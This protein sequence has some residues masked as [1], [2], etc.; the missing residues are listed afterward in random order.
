MLNPVVRLMRLTDGK[1]GATLG[2]VYHM[3]SEL[4]VAFEKPIEGMDEAVREKM[5]ALFMAR[6]TYFHKP[7]FT[8]A[9]FLDAE[10]LVGDGSEAEER[11][12]REV[13]KAVASAEHC[14]YS[15][16]EMVTQWA[17]LQTATN[18][19]S[20]GLHE[21]EAFSTTAKKM[22]CFEWA[23]TFLYNWPAIKY[24]AQRLPS[25][26]CSA[27]ICEHSW[28][29]EGWIHSKKRNRLGQ[30]HVERLVR[31]HTNLLLE[32]ALDEWRAEVLPWELEMII[33]E[34]ELEDE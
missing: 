1:T 8:A 16:V 6:W 25:L 5:W 7:V 3:M 26:A 19:K 14:P 18:V 24:V 20:H 23:R 2:K 31:T 30:K 32:R 15:Y 22:P 17:A 21:D 9:Y 12:F 10:F 13:L 11:E 34:P 33:Q 29:I 27:S 28:S 4:S